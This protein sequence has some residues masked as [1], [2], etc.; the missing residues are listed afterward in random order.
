MLQGMDGGSSSPPGAVLGRRFEAVVFAWDGPGGREERSDGHALREVLARLSATGFE[1][2]AVARAP[3][4]GRP[5]AGVRLVE[6]R[7]DDGSAVAAA[8]H[9]LADAGIDPELVLVGGD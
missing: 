9:E 1:A 2:V 4:D 8:L 6:H 5:P 7:D 3:V